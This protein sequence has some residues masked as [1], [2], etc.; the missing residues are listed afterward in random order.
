MIGPCGPYVRGDR[1]HRT[2]KG[3]RHMMGS[4]LLNK[5]ALVTGATSNIGRA[6]ATSFAA[7]GAH[8]VV[9]GRSRE[10]GG[11]VLDEIRASGG[12]A[13]FVAAHLDGSA[14][15]SHDLAAEA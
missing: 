6:I 7:E 9:S 1:T 4:C 12:R 5:T 14:R 10:R 15:V 2:A 13:D 3:S 11:E 8:V